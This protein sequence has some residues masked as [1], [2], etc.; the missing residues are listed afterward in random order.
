MIISSA[1][2]PVTIP[3]TTI[4]E[5]VLRHADR[6]AAKAA[7]IDG[8]SGRTLTYGTL[9]DGIRRVA[10]ALAQRGFKKGD[11]FAIYSPNLPEYAIVFLG[12]ASI[13]GGGAAVNPLYTAGGPAEQR[14]DCKGR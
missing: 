1:S 13:G 14:Q 5:F 9:T 8:P 2:P 4:T 11:V 3:E 6:L 7:L 12:V 10:T